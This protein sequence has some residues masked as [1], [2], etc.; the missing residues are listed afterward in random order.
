MDFI[1]QNHV[2]IDPMVA[3]SA[4]VL[5]IILIRQLMKIPR[6]RRVAELEGD[7]GWRV[8]AGSSAFSNKPAKDIQW[9]KL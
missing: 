6:P 8:M 9:P 2:W 5:G 1:T 4:G 7:A 3:L